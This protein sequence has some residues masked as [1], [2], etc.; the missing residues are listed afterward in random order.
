MYNIFIYILFSYTNLLSNLL[1]AICELHQLF[2]SVDNIS[3]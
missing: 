1:A 3:W 2:D